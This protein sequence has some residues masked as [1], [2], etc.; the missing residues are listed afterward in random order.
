MMT[1]AP[2]FAKRLAMPSPI[3][4]VLPVTDAQVLANKVDMVAIVVEACRIHQK[5]AHRMMQTLRAVDANVIG[6]ILN[7]KTGTAAKYY[8]SYNYYGH[9]KYGGYYGESTPEEKPGFLKT[10]WEKLNS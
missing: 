4:P 1:A 6:V 5:A 10:A 9:K 2:S 7:D 3:P 8:G